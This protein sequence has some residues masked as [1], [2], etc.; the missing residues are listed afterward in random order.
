MEVSILILE[1]IGTVA[2]SASGA[3]IGI[4]KNMDLLGIAMLGL[5]T[6]AGGGVIRDLVLGIH[7]PVLFREPVYAIVALA[8]ALVLFLPPIRAF[9]ERNRRIYETV[10]FLMDTVG[11]AVFTVAGIRTAYLISSAYSTF[12]L[13][14][15]GV[16]TGVGG[17]ILR[18]ILAG[19][20]PYIFVKHV[21]ACASI[22]GALAC[23]LLWDAAGQGAAMAAGAAIVIV[24]RVLAAY[25]RWSL[26]HACPAQVSVG[27]A[28]AQ[29]TRD[30]ARFRRRKDA[31]GLR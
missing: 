6:A 3:M 5:V 13:V 30:T 14:F 15:V 27:N 17:G 12:L 21:Y 9:F 18:D 8:T 7:P 22:L 25:F 16:I 4:R 29:E 10:L 24:I 11:L 2:F 31:C 26:P 28:G 1:L 19:E 20:P 23:A